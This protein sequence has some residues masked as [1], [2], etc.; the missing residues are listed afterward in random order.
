MLDH[1]YMRRCL[2]LAQIAKGHVSPNPMVGA[3]IVA[4]ERIIGEG[5]HTAA[6]QPHAEINALHSVREAD[7]PLLPKSTLYVNLEPCHHHGKTPPCTHAIQAAGIKRVVIAGR[8]P[9][10]LVS[11]KGIQFLRS[12]GV[13][14]T[15]GVLEKD[16]ERL[17]APF[18]TFHRKK[19]PYII[20]KWA[21][22]EDFFIG[23][24]DRQI[25]ISSTQTNKLNHLWRTEADAI[26]IGTQTAIVD[27]PRL[28]VRHVSGP[29]PLRLVL[30]RTGRIPLSQQI[31]TDPFPLVIFT[32]NPA[33]FHRLP[34]QKDIVS[35][36]FLPSVLPFLMEWAYHQNL[37]S[38][39]VE[40]GRKL[41]QSFIDNHLWDEARIIHNTKLF[42]DHGIRCPK[43]RGK[44]LKQLL[45][46]N[47][48]V[49]FVLPHIQ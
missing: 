34:T 11:G 10:P 15:L 29:N 23:K 2:E 31:F 32:E 21:E 45:I 20:L 22:S 27:N 8:D 6:G 37:Q 13:D 18:L 25:S 38:I 3:V 43:L 40:G 49:T 16:A 9:N 26:L 47:D 36:P 1:D 24:R 30:D 4:D 41:L 39:I 12:I 17:N 44:R 14:I 5:L 46:E 42:L 33:Y 35:A 28:T 48:S 7:L 19:R